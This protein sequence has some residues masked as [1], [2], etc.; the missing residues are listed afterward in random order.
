M[1]WLSKRREAKLNRE[2]KEYRQHELWL[3]SIER[4]WRQLAAVL[5]VTDEDYPE[6]KN[7]AERMPV[8]TIAG[9]MA[10]LILFTHS[11]NGRNGGKR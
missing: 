3:E 4:G 6:W 11:F 2:V 7:Y 1:S 8:S 10:Q 5:G 9:T